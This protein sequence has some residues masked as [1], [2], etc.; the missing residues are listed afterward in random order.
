MPIKTTVYNIS[1]LALKVEF[2]YRKYHSLF[3]LF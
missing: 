2:Y 1:S 3:Q